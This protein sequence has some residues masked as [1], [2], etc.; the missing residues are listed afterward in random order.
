MFYFSGLTAACSIALVRTILT[1]LRSA[2]SSINLSPEHPS[3][4]LLPAIVLLHHFSIYPFYFCCWTSWQVKKN[5]GS[6][7]HTTRDGDLENESANTWCSNLRTE[8]IRGKIRVHVAGNKTIA[9][10]MAGY[11][12]Q[13]KYLHIVIDIGTILHH[14]DWMEWKT[15]IVPNLYITN[16][17]GINPKN[18]LCVS[19]LPSCGWWQCPENSI[20]EWWSDAKALVLD[21]EVVIKV[22]PLHNRKSYEE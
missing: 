7:C 18:V 2:V 1:G 13:M 10:N 6:S 15:S 16:P 19:V 21:S 11:I 5:R 8:F 20:P 3:D 17:L 14:K 4:I 12:R 22:I 9:P